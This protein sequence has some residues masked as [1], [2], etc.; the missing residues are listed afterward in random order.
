MHSHALSSTITCLSVCL[1]DCS[2]YRCSHYCYC[3]CCR[4]TKGI[5]LVELCVAKNKLWSVKATV[6][7]C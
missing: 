6:R 1:S 2:H 3:C 4:P 5:E 7:C